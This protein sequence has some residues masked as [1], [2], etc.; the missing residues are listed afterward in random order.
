VNKREKGEIITVDRTGGVVQYLNSQKMLYLNDWQS[1]PE[2]N[3]R[4]LFFLSSD[5]AKNP[6]YRLLT[7]YRL[8][9]GKVNALDNNAEF[10]EFNGMSEA[11][12]I[13]LVLGKM[14]PEEKP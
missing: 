7:A 13:K 11:D 10:Q 1:L 2:A 12:F 9:E 6:N 5:D 8:K 3:G 4:Y 14:Q